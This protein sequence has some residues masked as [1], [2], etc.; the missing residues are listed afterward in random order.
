MDSLSYKSN[1]ST[2]DD[3]LSG[4]V[5]FLVAVPL[6]LGVAQATGVPAASGL[7]AG[8][9]GGI[10]VGLISGSQISVTGPSPGL[11]LIVTTQLTVL[12]S[13]EAILTA[14]VL[15]GLL[16]VAAGYC[17]VGVFADFIPTSVVRGV[18]AAFGVIFILKQFPHMLGHD[19]DPEGEMAFWQPD[20]ETTFSE[21][22]S[23]GTD[24]HIGSA[25]VGI[26]CF[27]LLIGLEYRKFSKL[28][29][30]P[31]SLI[32]IMVALAMATIFANLG[33]PWAIDEKHLFHVPL[34]NDWG[35]VWNYLHAP[36]ASALLN[37]K[38]YLVAVMIAAIG[39]L[40]S[41]ISLR[42][43]DIL[44][45]QGRRSPA[46]RELVAQGCGNALAGLVGGLPMT[47]LITHSAVNIKAHGRTKRATILHGCFFLL[48]VV[49]FPELLNRIPLSCLAAI[50]MFVSYQLAQPDSFVRAWR[51][52][53][54]Q[55]APFIITLL[56]I[57]FTDLLPGILIGLGVSIAFILHSNLRR[58]L[59]RTLEKHLGGEVFVIELANQ[60]S[61]LNRAVLDE[62]LQKAPR[63]TNILIDASNSE[64]IDPDIMN[65]IKEFK[66]ITA[67]KHGVTV[68]LKGFRDKYQIEDE[69]N[70]V[71]YSTRELQSQLNPLQVLQILKDGNERFLSGKRLS[72]DLGRQI[73][74]TSAG[75]HPLAIVLSCIDSR[76]PTELILDLG[77]GDIFNIR[78]AGNVVGP[79]VLASI[80]YGTAV[81]G[82]KLIVVMGH[83]RC[84]A[85]T[86]SVQLLDSPDVS[87]ATGC[88][89]LEA[90]VDRVRE[91]ID[92]REWESKKH[93]QG[94]E[95]QDYADKVARQ[96]VIRHVHLIVESSKTVRRLVDE[97]KVAVVGAMYD[98]K[99]GKMEFLAEAQI[100]LST[101]DKREVGV[102]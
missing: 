19:A 80:E 58:P 42:A 37:P 38:V 20:R 31:S 39:S 33:S 49:F 40:E 83:T 89:H 47:C 45:E 10:V 32:A 65:M 8:I 53:A 101:S 63:G 61:F 41:L 21:L 23:M 97:G 78:V 4:L 72:R 3:L 96:N 27:L 81:A 79:K 71:D 14:T 6:S 12:G 102:S 74:Q 66:D 13:F 44:D 55:F 26:T 18:L 70:Y 52:G 48:S 56:A 95:K 62:T 5:I 22:L 94:E 85:V 67:A 57:L 11:I 46:N 68:S 91:C 28:L 84:G 92:V 51:G 64:Y 7:L 34:A 2:L 35:K 9:I 73:M 1:K 82:A 98:V 36:A 16:Q 60:V 93:L 86:A 88:E 50:L 30:I 24:W 54:Y 100:A 17:K 15:A 59:T 99:T 69:I 77:L 87:V 25:A 90:I 29:P 75:Q 76:T 43:V